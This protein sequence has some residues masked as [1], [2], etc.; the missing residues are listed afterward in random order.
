MLDRDFTKRLGVIG[1]D[2]ELS[3]DLGNKDD[4]DDCTSGCKETSLV[5]VAERDLRRNR[6]RPTESEL[7]DRCKGMTL[8]ADSTA[9]AKVLGLILA[10]AF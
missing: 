7:C 8:M 10:C 6:P 3:L 9:D 4:P 5:G 2:S 1:R